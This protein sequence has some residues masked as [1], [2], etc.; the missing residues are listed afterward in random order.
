MKNNSN[1]KVEN[2]SEQEMLECNGGWGWI[3]S[4]AIGGMAFAYQLGKDS[5]QVH[6]ESFI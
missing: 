4:A 6:P 5:Y 1:F 2:L 3:V